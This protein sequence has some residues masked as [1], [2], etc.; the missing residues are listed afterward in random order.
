M[1]LLRTRCGLAVPAMSTCATCTR[2]FDSDS[3]K[4]RMAAWK[5]L[6]RPDGAGLM[7]PV[8]QKRERRGVPLTLRGG[9]APAER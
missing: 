8:C 1:D 3:F 6:Q 4:G 5:W 9:G 2:P 7:C